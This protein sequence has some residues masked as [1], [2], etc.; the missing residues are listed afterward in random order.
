[1]AAN[2]AAGMAALVTQI[3]AA[4]AGLSWMFTEW[5]V[6]KKPSMIGLVR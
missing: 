3:A 5:L 2:G 4:M 6:K 1:M